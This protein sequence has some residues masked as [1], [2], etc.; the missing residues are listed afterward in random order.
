MTAA[1]PAWVYEAWDMST[2]GPEPGTDLKT[3]IINIVAVT[4]LA[5]YGWDIGALEKEEQDSLFLAAID[6]WKNW[7]SDDTEAVC[8]AISEKLKSLAV[9]GGWDD[10]LV[11]RMPWETD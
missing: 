9:A 4:C 3:D 1:F 6:A 7:P 11:R 2:A 5:E 8:A 10:S